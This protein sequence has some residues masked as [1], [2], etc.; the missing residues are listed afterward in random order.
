MELCGKITAIREE[1]Q[2]SFLWLH[3]ELIDIL[4]NIPPVIWGFWGRWAI[5]GCTMISIIYSSSLCLFLPQFFNILQ[6]NVFFPLPLMIWVSQTPS[7]PHSWGFDWVWPLAFWA[8]TED[9]IWILQVWINIETHN[10]KM[11]LILFVFSFI[12]WIDFSVL[13][14]TR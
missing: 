10:K 2:F 14:C 5:N 12:Y 13:L 3:S 1:I 9:C 7:W 4:W 6:W 11:L 8:L